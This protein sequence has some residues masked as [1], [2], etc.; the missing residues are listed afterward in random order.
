MSVLLDIP[1][2]FLLWLFSVMEL[3][4][5]MLLAKIFPGNHCLLNVSLLLCYSCV[6]HLG[7]STVSISLVCFS[8]S[9]RQLD[10]VSPLF[11]GLCY[12]IIPD[13]PVFSYVLS[14]CPVFSFSCRIVCIPRMI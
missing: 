9:S 13:V 8:I 10:D 11:V 6:L 12:V 1:L 7:F 3:Q 4:C 2:N 14:R 5:N